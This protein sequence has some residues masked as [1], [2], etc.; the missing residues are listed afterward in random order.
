MEKYIKNMLYMVGILISL[1]D[2]NCVFKKLDG[3]L[4]P[5]G[6]IK[7][8]YYKK[9]VSSLRLVV[10]GVLKE[11]RHKGI[12]AAMYEKGLKNAIKNGY[13]RCELSWILD[14]N[15]MAQRTAEMMN[16]KIY[17]KYAI[18]GGYID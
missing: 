8:L 9:K 15:V 4:F 11:Y 18:Y 14:D 16:G 5:F 3:K 13:K 10:M 17:K 12:E 2:Y 6:M 7:F 1:P